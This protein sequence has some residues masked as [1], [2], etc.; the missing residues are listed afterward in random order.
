MKLKTILPTLALACGTAWAQPAQVSGIDKANMDLT[1]N[2]GTDFYQY[3]T[4]GW[5]EAH[6]LTAEYARYSQFELLAENNRRQL[7]DGALDELKKKLFEDLTAYR[8]SEENN[9]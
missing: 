1:A 5:R 7:R 2:P 8:H 3:A 6:P 9:F 4:G